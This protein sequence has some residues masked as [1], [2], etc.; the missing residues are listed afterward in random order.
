MKR[1]ELNCPQAIVRDIEEH[2]NGYHPKFGRK[3]SF[4]G[5]DFRR[6]AF[7]LNQRC[8]YAREKCGV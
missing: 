3:L 5:P 6:I 4:P 1:T 7:V 2:K 8:I